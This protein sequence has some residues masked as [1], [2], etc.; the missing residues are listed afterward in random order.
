MAEVTDVMAGV[1]L[2]DVLQIKSPRTGDQWMDFASIKDADDMKY[3]RQMLMGTHAQFSKPDS[4][5]RVMGRRGVVAEMV[6]Q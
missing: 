3:T 5:F 6:K 2:F 1:E 4:E